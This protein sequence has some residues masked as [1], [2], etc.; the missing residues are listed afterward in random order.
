MQTAI[1]GSSARSFAARPTIRDLSIDNLRT[2]A[3]LLLLPFHT[4][5]LYSVL[6]YQLHEPVLSPGAHSAAM[7]LHIWHMPLLFLL[8]GASA[9]AGLAKRGLGRF[10][11]ER[12]LRL[13]VP[14]LFGVLVL[15]PPMVYLERISID[16]A[17]RWSPIDF[18]G[19]FWAF[20]PQYFRCCY[21]EANLSYHHLWFLNYLL[22]FSLVLWPAWR[23]LAGPGG[24]RLAERL[25]PNPEAGWRLLLPGLILV[26]SEVLL[27]P[28]S[29]YSFKFYEDWARDANY[30]L[31]L[32]F[33]GWLFAQP[34]LWEAVPR[35]TWAA[36]TL[37]VGCTALF[38]A[39]D[40]NHGLRTWSQWR[41][42]DW[43]AHASWAAAEWCWIVAL[44]GLARRFLARPIPFVTAFAPLSLSFYVLHFPMVIGTAF[45]LLD[46][47]AAFW[48]KFPVQM[49]I[50]GTL[51]YA[52][53]R[54]FDLTPV[55]RVLLGTRAWPASAR[56]E[57]KAVYPAAAD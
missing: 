12:L 25:V 26:A 34:R 54:L 5:L 2:L 3:V 27:N 17:N 51:T 6:P 39:L 48:V 14:L 8:A 36:L 53:C 40:E 7:V 44:V 1:Q 18:D 29:H 15:V 56:P 33:G 45:V 11:G 55:T 52:L 30:I 42:A 47:P 50:A 20:Y 37:A 28:V 38:F 22:V 35:A 16:V 31:A 49:A 19:S 23:W 21:P 4:L 57:R 46:W 32:L 9:S 41:S 10:L 43:Y 24:A 13:G